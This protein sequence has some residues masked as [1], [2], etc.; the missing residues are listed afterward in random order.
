MIIPISCE[1]LFWFAML[2]SLIK[3]TCDILPALQETRPLAHTIGYCPETFGFWMFG[4]NIKPESVPKIRHTISSCV[5]LGEE[6]RQETSVEQ[7][8]YSGTPKI[9]EQHSYRNTHR[10]NSISQLHLNSKILCDVQL[11]FPQCWLLWRVG[12]RYSFSTK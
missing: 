6:V 10:T 9:S 2:T 4:L 12:S 8:Q 7:M 11:P 1:L 5:L 3:Y